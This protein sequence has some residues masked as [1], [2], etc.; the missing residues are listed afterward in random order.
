MQDF[1]DYAIKHNIDVGPKMLKHFK[2]Y[3]SL[4]TLWN[5]KFNL[6]AINEPEEIWRKHFLDSLTVLLALPKDAR[7]VID[8]GSG[9]GFPGLPIAIVRPNLDITL[10]EATGK[11]VK[12]LE[13]VIQTLGLKNA[14]A[15]HGRAESTK[16]KYDVVLARAVA[17]L[18]TL[19]GYAWQLLK[20]DGIMIAQK[21]SGGSEEID[22]KFVTEVIPID[23]PYLPARE[24]VV[25]KKV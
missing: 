9:A 7:R 2:T 1:V 17:A 25:I 16:G 18:P 6:T 11:K 8:I 21:K 4:L 13:H 5:L 23:L 14:K 19:L 3:L 15:V 20:E 24:L 12:F 22:A 10:L